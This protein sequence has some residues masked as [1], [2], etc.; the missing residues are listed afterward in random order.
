MNNV[1]VIQGRRGGAFKALLGSFIGLFIFFIPLSLWGDK[2][3]IPLVSLI[4]AIKG[5]LGDN[6]KYLTLALT[7]LLVVTWLASRLT[8]N[9][10]LKKY[11]HKD[12]L[13]VGLLFLLGA[14]F[15]GLLVFQIGPEWFLHKDV[16]GLALYLGGSVFL[17]V[18]I[19]GFLV[20]F[21]T[22]FGFLEFVGTLM[23]PLMRPFYR[24]PGRSAVD[25]VASFVAAPAVGIFITNKLYRSG[26]YTQR[27]AASI[28]T[29]FSICSLGFFALLASI[30]G[31]MEYLPHMIVSSFVINF[32][33]AA[34]VTRL[35]PLS[36]KPDCYFDGRMQRQQRADDNPEGSILARACQAA[37][38]RAATTGPEVF[39]RYL[40]EA[41]TFA[42]K[43]VAYILSIATI[44]LVIGTYT[45]VFEYLGVVF[46]PLLNLLQLPD[47]DKVAPTVLLS[48]A[49]IAL[50]AIIIAGGDV[51]PMSVF[52][53]CT[54][55]TIQIIF[56]TESANAMLESDIPL[57]VKD[58]VIIFLIR[59]LLAIPLV[60]LAA[61]LIF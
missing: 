60:A 12:N 25:A 49:E 37:A 23:E 15:A 39:G 2:A 45:P 18:V 8:S 59:T 11:H 19:A 21:L 44:A 14:V 32:L 51:A 38:E 58:L 35:P 50:P 46:E 55:S 41:T 36:R 30:G 4:G 48:I 28:A 20:L 47:A 53:V 13:L 7:L 9:V 1:E 57:S 54:L 43:I 5:S 26:H 3:T 34:V 27:E 6:L 31:I 22:E 61:H 56:F 16:G 10:A 33:L 24:L 40:W 52:F 29:N 17:T 42:Q